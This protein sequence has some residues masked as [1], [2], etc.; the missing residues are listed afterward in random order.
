MSSKKGRPGEEKIIKIIIFNKPNFKTA[1]S[2]KCR[3]WSYYFADHL[4][5]RKRFT[6][7]FTLQATKTVVRVLRCYIVNN[8]TDDYRWHRYKVKETPSTFNITG[9]CVLESQKTCN[10]CHI[11]YPESS[12]KKSTTFSPKTNVLNVPTKLPSDEKNS[13]GE[14]ARIYILCG[15][16]F[17]EHYIVIASE[18]RLPLQ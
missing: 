14:M 2:I 4:N 7:R 6:L 18:D 10:I 3:Q 8:H 1:V 11:K 5:K 12:K 16:V 15:Y 13:R 17:L 9:S